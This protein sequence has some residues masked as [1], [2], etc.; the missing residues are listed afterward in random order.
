MVRPSALAVLRL[1]TGSNFGWLFDRKVGGLRGKEFGKV[2]RVLPAYVREEGRRGSSQITPP[3]PIRS[4]N[5]DVARTRG[6][7]RVSRPTITGEPVHDRATPALCQAT[8]V[9]ARPRDR[10]T[11][12]ACRACP[13]R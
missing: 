10:P 12:R 8:T 9:A 7:L 11:G 13:H 4:L 5:G 1:I 6:L 2:D 3:R